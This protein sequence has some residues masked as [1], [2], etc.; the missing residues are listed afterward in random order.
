MSETTWCTIPTG[1][2]NLGCGQGFA[3]IYCGNLRPCPVHE[4][5]EE[6]PHG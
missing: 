5:L 1:S 3:T 4:E 2:V 6:K